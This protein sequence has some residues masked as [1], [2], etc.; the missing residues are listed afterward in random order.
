VNGDENE[1]IGFN[2]L[3][4]HKGNIK[5]TPLAVAFSGMGVCGREGA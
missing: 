5:M 4:I 3:H 2:G 1:G